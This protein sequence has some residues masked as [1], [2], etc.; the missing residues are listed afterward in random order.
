MVPACVNHEDREGNN[1][2]NKGTVHET[3]LCEECF[4]NWLEDLV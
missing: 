1:V 2:L 3:Y 4:E